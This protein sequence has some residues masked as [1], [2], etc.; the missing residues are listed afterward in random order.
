MNQ[1]L[2]QIHK[3]VNVPFV[4]NL[5]IFIVA[6]VVII[7][8]GYALIIGCNIKWN[9]TIKDNNKRSLVIILVEMRLIKYMN[10][11]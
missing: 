7:I 5:L 4:K 1:L 9:I 11:I 8:S 2:Y 10:T 6:T 3:K